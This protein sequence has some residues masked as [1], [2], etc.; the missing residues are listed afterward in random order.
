MTGACEFAAMALPWRTFSA[1]SSA[2]ASTVSSCV[3]A[4]STSWPHVDS[5]PVAY[6]ETWPD[7]AGTAARALTTDKPASF[8][9]LLTHAVVLLSPLCGSDPQKATGTFPPKTKKTRLVA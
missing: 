5:R 7:E 8:G 9:T 4:F 6:L 3:L 1:S 2:R